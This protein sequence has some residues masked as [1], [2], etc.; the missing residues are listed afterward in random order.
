MNNEKN[1]AITLLLKNSEHFFSLG[2]I[3]AGIFLLCFSL[4]VQNFNYFCFG[5]FLLLCIA[6]YFLI[7]KNNIIENKYKICS[8]KFNKVEDILFIFLYIPG[9]ITLYVYP[10][11]YERPPLFF[12]FYICMLGLILVQ[13][14][15]GDDKHAKILVKIICL[16]LFYILSQAL[17][18]KSL[19]SIDSFIHMYWTDI[20]LS[21]G[22]IPELGIYYSYLFHILHAQ[23]QMI[24]GLD[25]NYS[26]LLV[27][28][29]SMMI[30]TTC[31][32]FLIGRKLVT[33]QVGLLSSFILICSTGF[34]YFSL[35]L[36]PNSYS[37]IF[38]ILALL[39]L[40]SG[41]GSNNDFW[42]IILLLFFILLITLTHPLTNLLIV[43]ILPVY[44]FI[45]NQKT[46]A[47]LKIRDQDFFLISFSLIIM[48]VWWI[49]SIQL[50]S[51]SLDFILSG[52][53]FLELS[54]PE[55][56]LRYRIR[57]NLPIVEGFHMAISY[58]IF[59]II[60]IPGCLYLIKRFNDM[61][62]VAFSFAGLSIF[63]LLSFVIITGR[64]FI[65]IRF[66]YLI[67][68]IFCIFA[69]IF[70]ILIFQSTKKTW[71]KVVVVG[72]I[73]SICIIGIIHPLANITNPIYGR[74]VG[75]Q[76]Y[77]FESE[78][79][80]LSLLRI[81][82]TK[83]L[84]SDGTFEFCERHSGRTDITEINANIK[85][86]DFYNIRHHTIIISDSIF[87]GGY[88]KE[89]HFPEKQIVVYSLGANKFSKFFD[90]GRARS[91]I[92]S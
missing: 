71:L 83:P 80:M 22:N 2:V 86:L 40:M 81:F 57:L 70:I 20:I 59:W 43:I 21:T 90:V 65:N 64:E 41:Y 39:I 17:L 47:T 37:S 48:F 52:M 87:K 25:Y 84:A 5:L 82:D 7:R 45:W 91:Y 55:D 19:M 28:L 31:T 30:C 38:F 33:S 67:S 54:H 34:V 50:F 9:I 12:L 3:I 8:T 32:I 73:L 74:P 49:Y 76:I 53:N 26:N 14:I 78:S 89:I 1:N 60:G 4:Y 72:I 27:V 10:I 44:L 62:G 51:H 6:I 16:A 63:G 13:I 66:Y 61:K 75:P 24:T 29:P 88:S 23:I 77:P 36:I 92:Y 18:F 46:N 35:N 68:F 15:L 58:F 79:A 56:A 11:P 85:F 69:A 42:Y